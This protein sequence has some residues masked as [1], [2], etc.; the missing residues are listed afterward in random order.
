MRGGRLGGKVKK[1]S[2]LCTGGNYLNPIKSARIHTAESFSFTYGKVEVKAKLPRGDWLWPAIWMLPRD[3]QYGDWPSSGEVDI[4]E[5]RGNAPSYPPGGCDSFGSTLHW[6]V[7]YQYDNYLKTHAEKKGV[8]LTA[9]FHTYGFLWNE[10]YMGTYFDDESNVVLNYPIIKS[11][12]NQTGLPSPPW[13]NPWVGAA[14][15]APFDQRFYLVINLAVGGTNGYFPDGNGKPWTDDSPHAVNEFYDAKSK[16]Y[17]TWNGKQSALQIDSVK[18][19]TYNQQNSPNF[20]K[21]D[22]V[23]EQSGSAYLITPILFF[24]FVGVF[25]AFVVCNKQ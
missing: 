16:W 3:N 12:W 10:T 13:A 9:D 15:N 20:V 4:M 19:W 24:L 14:N 11:F 1:Q 8:D 5:S 22:S 2:L 6:G 25:L 18:V 21:E 7:S 23:S 17:A